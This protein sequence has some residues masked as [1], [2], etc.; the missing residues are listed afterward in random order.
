MQIILWILIR[1]II[2]LAYSSKWYK[3]SWIIALLEFLL[4]NKTT[5]VKGKALVSAQVRSCTSTKQ[6]L[7]FHFLLM[8]PLIRHCYHL[9]FM[10]F[11]S[12]SRHFHLPFIH[13]HLSAIPTPSSVRCRRLGCRPPPWHTEW[14]MALPLKS[15]HTQSYITHV[16]ENATLS[17]PLSGYTPEHSRGILIE[18][19]P[20]AQLGSR[21]W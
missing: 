15:G 1:S 4:Q 9:L 17:L 5:C 13:P 21:L 18:M 10:A 3:I 11:T 6:L 14:R 8:S 16:R 7:P 20:G 19:L 12:S 2:I